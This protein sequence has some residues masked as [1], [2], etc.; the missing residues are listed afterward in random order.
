LSYYPY[1]YAIGNIEIRFPSLG[2]EK[3]FV[4][5]T[6]RADTG[7]LTDQ[8]ALQSILTQPQNRYLSRQVCWVL[9]IE[10]LDHY[11]LQPREASDYDLLLDAVRV[12]P[13]RQ[14]IDVVIGVRGP[15]APPSM[16]NGLSVPIVGFSQIYSF[17]RDSFLNSV[18]VPEKQDAERFRP[19][20][21]EVFDRF[22]KVVDNAGATDE[23]RALNYLATRY[24]AVYNLSAERFGAGF[25]L[26]S[27]ETAPSRLSGAR[28]LINVSIVFTHRETQLL[29]RYSVR[30]DVTEEFPF[31][32]STLTPAPYIE[33]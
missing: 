21:G 7:G 12:N 30:V 13:N 4:Q 31:L 22:L 23:H 8:Q 17:D 20:V 5:A 33:R 3:E 32:S 18:P 28:R 1:I 24:P 2:V 9:T 11:L 25:S 10:G 29:D 26:T 14:D 15:I 6:G 19:T 16:C 27:I